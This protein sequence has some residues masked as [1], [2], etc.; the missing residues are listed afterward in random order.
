MID[1]NSPSRRSGRALVI[2][3]S[4]LGPDRQRTVPIKYKSLVAEASAWLD[5]LEARQ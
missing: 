5:E 2:R 1:L 3:T 4:E